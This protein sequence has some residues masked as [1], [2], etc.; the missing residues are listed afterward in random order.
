[1]FLVYGNRVWGHISISVSFSRFFKVICNLQG[2][3]RSKLD[4]AEPHRTNVQMWSVALRV[5]IS[6]INTPL[7]FTSQNIT[8]SSCNRIIY[9][10]IINKMFLLVRKRRTYF[11]QIKFAIRTLHRPIWYVRNQKKTLQLFWQ[12]WKIGLKI[13]GAWQY[14]PK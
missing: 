12:F 14:G 3:F 7:F 8:K 6:I 13:L 10:E 5:P 4:I 11:F 2:H 1:M 9:C